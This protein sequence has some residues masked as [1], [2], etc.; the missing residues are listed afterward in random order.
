MG[1]LTNVRKSDRWIYLSVPHMGGG[2]LSYIEDAFKDNWIST[3]GPNID[4]FER[5]VGEKYGVQSVALSSGTAAIHLALRVAGIGAGDEVAIPSLT[6]AATCNPVIYQGARPVFIDCERDSMNM[7]PECLEKMLRARERNGS[8]PKAIIVAHLFGESA[9]MD[10][11][12]ELAGKYGLIVIEDAAEAMGAKYRGRF[13][14]TMG[15]LGVFSFNGNKLITCSGGGMLV[16]RKQEWIESAR[17]LSMQARDPDPNELGD[18]IHS[19][20]GYNYRLSNVLAGIGCGQM[21][22][23]EQRIKERREV[24]M[25][26]GEGFQDIPGIRLF[27]ER[28]DGVSTRWLSCA[29]IDEETF[30]NTRDRLIRV[31]RANKVDCRPVWK[32]LHTQSAFSRF[33]TFGGERAVDFNRRG[34]CLPSS[35]SLSQKDQGEVIEI[36]RRVAAETRIFGKDEHGKS[37][38]D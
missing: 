2:E 30:G 28:E 19:Q 24:A 35:S 6:F 1:N 15:D 33:E 38:G 16:S 36:I 26:Y 27:S 4:R 20:T 10:P 11:I 8:L 32:P 29:L 17:H 34:I 37:F 23:L 13:C 9:D 21:E 22:V 31:L 5:Q 7:D 18:Y 3:V 12:L 14:G 25:R